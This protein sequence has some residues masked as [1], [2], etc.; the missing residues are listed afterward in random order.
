[1]ATVLFGIVYISFI[2]YLIV[3]PV[4]LRGLDPPEYDPISE[5]SQVMPS[6]IGGYT[7]FDTGVDDK[8]NE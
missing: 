1:M 8:M 3:K 2:V 5:N 7:M 4:K 6:T